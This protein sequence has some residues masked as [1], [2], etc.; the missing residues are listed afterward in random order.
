MPI[1][2]DAPSVEELHRIALYEGEPTSH[3]PSVSLKG[4][5]N[6]PRTYY[7]YEGVRGLRSLAACY[8]VAI[9]RGHPFT[10]GNKRTALLAMD[11]F[12]DQNGISFDFYPAEMEG[13]R[14]MKGVANGSFGMDYLAQWLMKYTQDPSRVVSKIRDRLAWE[15][16]QTR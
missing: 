10:D 9:T 2:L 15:I 4:L 6:R 3:N 7:H 13:V 14:L 1:W 8:G 11:A 5:L 16:Y 12:L